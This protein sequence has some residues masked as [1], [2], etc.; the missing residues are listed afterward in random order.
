[1]SL[2]VY[3]LAN[4]P[5]HAEWQNKREKSLA[6]AGE[7]KGLIPLIEQYYADREPEK[8]DELYWANI[9]H[10]LNKMAD[11]AGIYEHLW[12]P[13]EI[14]ITKAGELIPPL[15]EGLDKLK[16]NPDHYKTFNPSN[17]WGDYDGFV[18]W[19]ERYLKAC[20]ENPDGTINVS[21]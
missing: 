11:A 19:V 17:G 13:E 1:M 14:G 16:S 4:R 2:D 12:R 18:N 10:N 5:E 9:T 15:T 21:R 6:E 20:K 3:I 7:M 8:T